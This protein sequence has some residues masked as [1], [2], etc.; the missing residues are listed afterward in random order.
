MLL[1]DRLAEQQIVAALERGELD[2]LPGQGKPLQ[3]DDDS[4]V[5]AELRATYRIMK[6]SGLLPREIDQLKQIRSVESLL[7]Q[8][9]SVPEKKRLLLK[10]GVLRSKL[11]ALPLAASRSIDRQYQDK[12]IARLS[13]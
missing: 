7:A 12:I 6:N 1:V 13:K 4:A 5:P 3:L 9:E 8:A 11:S 10:L 2:N